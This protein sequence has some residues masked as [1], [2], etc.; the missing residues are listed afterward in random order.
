MHWKF[1]PNYV[2]LAKLVLGTPSASSLYHNHVWASHAMPTTGLLIVNSTSQ[3]VVTLVLMQP[4][5]P[6]PLIL[7]IPVTRLVQPTVFIS[8]LIPLVNGQVVPFTGG[9]NLNISMDSS[10]TNVSGSL[11]HTLGMNQ[12]SSGVIEN[13]ANP[14]RSS[15]V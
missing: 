7:R 10:T 8:S 4:T 6:N 3:Q 9:K 15:N 1:P 11:T 12:P 2:S 13:L 14:A 5:V